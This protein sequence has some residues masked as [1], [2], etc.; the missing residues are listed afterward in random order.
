MRPVGNAEPAAKAPPMKF[1][2]DKTDP[3]TVLPPQAF[4]H[5]L[6]AQMARL[7]HLYQRAGETSPPRLSFCLR[8]TFRISGI[9]FPNHALEPFRSGFNCPEGHDSLS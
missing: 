2:R 9:R 4:F 1:R 7:R 3:D 6:H 5:S 8:M